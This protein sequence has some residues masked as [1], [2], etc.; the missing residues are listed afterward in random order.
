MAG[1]E[2]NVFDNGEP[3]VAQPISVTEGDAELETT[4]KPPAPKRKAGR[5]KGS[6]NKPK[7]A[8]AATKAPK[9]VSLGIFKLVPDAPDLV[10]ATSGSACFDVCACL[11][12]GGSVNGYTGSNQPS[13]RNVRPFAQHQNKLGILIN[14]GDRLLIPTGLILDIPEGHSVRLHPRSGISLKQGLTLANAEGVIDS[15]YVE[16]LFVAV[17]N[18]SNQ[19]QAILDGERIAQGELIV[20][21]V[22]ETDFTI[23]NMRKAPE[24]K[25]ERK[26]GFGHTGK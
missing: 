18:Q 2:E 17:V 23:R 13:E 9:T 5:P 12:E 20:S 24:R 26:G 3:I 25:T 14:P 4:E 15:D 1:D 6:K 16:E 21:L 10:W 19:R 7:P 22:Q 11:K 8:Q